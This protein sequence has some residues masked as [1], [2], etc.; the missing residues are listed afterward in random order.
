M[1]EVHNK[2]SVTLRLTNADLETLTN[3]FVQGFKALAQ[4]TPLLDDQARYHHAD[5]ESARVTQ[6]HVLGSYQSW[7]LVQ[8]LMQADKLKF[9]YQKPG[10]ASSEE[11]PKTF[12]DNATLESHKKIVVHQVARWLEQTF[13]PSTDINQIPSASGPN[14]LDHELT[15]LAAMF[16][17]LRAGRLNEIQAFLVSNPVLADKYSMLTGNLPFFDN[18][19]YAQQSQSGDLFINDQ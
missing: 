5:R 6:R 8:R 18:C 10:G 3:D 12:V 16:E 13:T 9:T 11:C 17:Y 1:F 2:E 19:D 7:V 15:V 4:K 14:D